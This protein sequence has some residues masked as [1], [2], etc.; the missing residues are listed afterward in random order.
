MK[1]YVATRNPG[2]LRDFVTAAASYDCDIV[3]LP[4]LRNIKSPPED[5]PT[6]AENARAKALYYASHVPG[7][8]VVADDS[9]L[10]VDALAGAPGVRSARFAADAGIA[11]SSAVDAANNEYL[12]Q[13]LENIPSAQRTA[14]YRCA[15]A[16]AV[17]G[18]IIAEA[19]GTVEGLILLTPRGTAGFG[20]DPLFLIPHLDKTMAEIDLETKLTLSHRGAALRNLLN[21]LHTK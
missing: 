20:Y 2:K 14:R 13:R 17:D 5:A 15:L 1:L 11:S 10:E 12:L 7:L 3:P 19:E 21:M 8:T 16:A 4:H 6:F 9:G 18:R